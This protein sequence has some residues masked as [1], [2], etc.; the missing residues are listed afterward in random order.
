MRFPFLTDKIVEVPGA[1]QSDRMPFGERKKT[2]QTQAEL[3]ST[4]VYGV[5]KHYWPNLKIG[6]LCD[7][8]KTFHK[9]VFPHKKVH[10]FVLP[11]NAYLN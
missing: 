5:N 4:T 3:I 10:I 2:K 9:Y 11:N 6:G 7:H 8:F 1:R